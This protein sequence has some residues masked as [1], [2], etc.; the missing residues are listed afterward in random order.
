MAKKARDTELVFF[1]TKGH[2]LTFK[3]VFSQN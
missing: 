3:N 2:Q 1:D